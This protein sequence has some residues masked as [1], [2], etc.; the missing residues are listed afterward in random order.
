[1]IK[2]DEAQQQNIQIVQSEHHNEK[3]QNLKPLLQHLGFKESNDIFTKNFA[4]NSYLKV[5]FQKQE[6]IYPED[7][8]LK[9]NER[10][11]CNF[12]SAENMVVLEC[13]HRLLAK[14]YKP[15]HIEL[16]PKWKLGHGASGGRADILVKDQENKPLLLI[17]CKTFGKEFNKEWEETC[18]NGGQLF[19]YAQQIS[20][21]EYLCLYASKFDIKTKEIT[22]AHKIIAH[23]DNQ[24]ILENTKK[25]TQMK[26]FQEAKN[27]KERFEVWKKYLSIGI[28]H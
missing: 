23:K 28:Y 19:S 17:E 27:V 15:E 8:G 6:I 16:E 10:Q 13:V 21:V 14:G 9:V 18:Q 26:S 3:I 4:E 20:E 5:D 12:S 2:K 22:V 1:M 7:Q 11:T 24:K 25:E